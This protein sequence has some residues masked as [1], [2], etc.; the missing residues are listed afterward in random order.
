MFS[1]LSKPTKVGENYKPD[2]IV[3]VGDWVRIVTPMM[4]VRCGY[5]WTAERVREKSPELVKR[6]ESFL[7]ELEKEFGERPYGCRVG[8]N[9]M[10]RA[11]MDEVLKW[12]A[13]QKNWGDNQRRLFATL[14]EEMQDVLFCADEIFYRRSGFKVCDS[15]YG[16]MFHHQKTHKILVGCHDGY[17]DVKIEAI[18][19]EKLHP[20]E[21]W[22]V[23]AKCGQMQF[24]ASEESARTTLVDWEPCNH[25]DCRYGIEVSVLG[26]KLAE[27]QDETMIRQGTSQDEGQ[28][29][30]HNRSHQVT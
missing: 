16:N 23:C 21:R 27:D 13:Y 30:E 7:R 3:R 28:T 18:H 8:N 4:F 24:R 5:S 2:D 25:D 29:D 20:D 22:M 19:V 10:C 26:Q 14:N 17:R 11:V 6:V 1:L 12:D 15:E 9:R